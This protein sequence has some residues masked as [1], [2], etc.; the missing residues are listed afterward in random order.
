MFTNQHKLF[1]FMLS[2][3][4]GGYPVISSPENYVQNHVGQV[5]SEKLVGRR[6]LISFSLSKEFSCVCALHE[7]FLFLSSSSI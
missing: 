6:S 3:R 4:E 2:K 7:L 1:K 5:D